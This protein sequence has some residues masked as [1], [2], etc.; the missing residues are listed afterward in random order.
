ML[1]VGPYEDAQ[2]FVFHLNIG[3]EL[4]VLFTIQNSVILCYPSRHS[5]VTRHPPDDQLLQTEPEVEFKFA[6]FRLKGKKSRVVNGIV[7]LEPD[8][9]K[10]ALNAA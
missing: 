1:I 7:A 2:A 10:V 6:A 9:L 8:G 5:H 3:P 4:N